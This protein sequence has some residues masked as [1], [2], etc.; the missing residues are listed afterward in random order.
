M[1]FL[2]LLPAATAKTLA[3]EIPPPDLDSD[4]RVL[5]PASLKASTDLGQCQRALLVCSQ[6]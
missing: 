6:C 4:N 2:L 1:F 3:A 5:Y